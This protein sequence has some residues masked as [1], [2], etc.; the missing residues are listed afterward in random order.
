M[1][2][3]TDAASVK[4][5]SSRAAFETQGEKL[6]ML[7]FHPTAF[8]EGVAGEASYWTPLIFYAVIFLIVQVISTIISA[9]RDW[10]TMANSAAGAFAVVTFFVISIF[11]IGF[12]ALFA[13]GGPF[14]TAGLSH[15]GVMAFKGKNGY[16]NTYKPTTYAYVIGTIYGLFILI[17]N[18]LLKIYQPLNIVPD[19][20]SFIDIF[21]MIPVSYYIVFGII[22]LISMIHTISA[23]VI[24]IS[25]FQSISKGKAFLA[26]MVPQVIMMLIAVIIFI[27]LFSFIAALAAKA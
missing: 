27:L 10:S 13:C 5:K 14:I 17:A 19:I 7:F 26:V 6:K 22:G 3:V 20:T 11:S 4:S 15:L 8:F 16:F 12:A 18:N 21:R 24:G 23:E 9:I 1:A 2:N 25:K